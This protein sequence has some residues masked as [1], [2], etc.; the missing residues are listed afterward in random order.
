[1]IIHAEFINFGHYNKLYNKK[2]FKYEFYKIQRLKC[3]LFKKNIN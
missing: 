3:Q 2:Y 1:M